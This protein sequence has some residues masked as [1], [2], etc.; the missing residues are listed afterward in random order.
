MTLGSQRRNTL[1]SILYELRET[2][3]FT[4]PTYYSNINKG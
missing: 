4:V 1:K 2:P 3:F